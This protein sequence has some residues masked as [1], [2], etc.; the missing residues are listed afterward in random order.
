MCV[1]VFLGKFFGVKYKNTKSGE[2]TTESWEFPPL[3]I[4]SS[5]VYDP[6][7]CLSRCLLSG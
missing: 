6:P 3:L 5:L 2:E 1:C 4:G 7:F